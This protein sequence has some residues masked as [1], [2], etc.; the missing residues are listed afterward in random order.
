M[1]HIFVGDYGWPIPGAIRLMLDGQ[2]YDA[3]GDS[4]T[5]LYCKPDG[6]RVQRI[7][8]IDGDALIYEAEEGLIDQPGYWKLRIVVITPAQPPV[9]ARRRQALVRFPVYP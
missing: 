7:C 9:A 2:P 3:T 4:V 5:F 6:S 1:S 8:T